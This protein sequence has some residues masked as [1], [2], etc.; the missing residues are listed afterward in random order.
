MMKSFTQ[1]LVLF[2]LVCFAKLVTC[3]TFTDVAQTLSIDANLSTLDNYGAS[4]SFYDFNQDGLD[5]LTF[6]VENDSILFYENT[7]ADFERFYLPIY[8]NG[9]VKQVAWVDID[10]DHDLD[11]FISVYNGTPRLLINDGNFNFTDNSVQ[12]GLPTVSTE[13][14]GVSF[15]DFNNDSYLDF[16]LANYN[17]GYSE[18]D[19]TRLN[20]LYKNNGDGT[21]DNITLSAGVGDSI[22]TSF[23]G[24]W[25]DYDRDGWI[26]L[27]VINDR[28]P[29]EN[30]L[31]KNNGN[32]TFTDVTAGS[33]LGFPG[34]NPMTITI[35]DFNNDGFPDIYTTNIGNGDVTQ[36]FVNNGDGTFSEHSQALGTQ[37]NE[38]TWGAVWIDYDND[39]WEDLYVATGHPSSFFPQVESKF[40]KNHNGQYFTFQNN[41]FQ[42]NMTGA[43]YSVAKGDLN[44]DGFYDIISYND[45]L[46]DPYLWLNSGGT[47][48]Y[49]KLTLEGTT[50]N[51]NAIGAQIRV[52]ANGNQYIKSVYSV[53]NY[54][55]QN[56]Q[57][58]IFGL[59]QAQV[60]D[61]IRVLYPSGKLDKYYNV[62]VNE[63]HYL[64][65][66]ETSNIQV[67]YIG[68]SIFCDNSN[69][70]LFINTPDS[71]TWNNNDDSTHISINT[72]GSYYAMI[73]QPGF[74]FFTDTVQLQFS[75]M[76][77]I[78]ENIESASCADLADGSIELFIN[79]N[80]NSSDY[81]LNWSNGE[82]GLSIINLGAGNYTYYYQDI[83]GCSD[84]TTLNVPSPSPIIINLSVQQELLGG[85]GNIQLIANGGTPPYDYYFNGTQLA[86]PYENLNQGQYLIEILD[87]NNCSEDTLVNVNSILSLSEEAEDHFRIGPNPLIGSSF[88]IEPMVPSENLT[89][90]IYDAT[91]KE[92]FAECYTDL[93]NDKL[94]LDL[95]NLKKGIYHLAILNSEGTHHF[96]LHKL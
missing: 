46:E 5:D 67:Q 74:S 91:G 33:G 76:P 30:T 35:D 82:T 65:E 50:S 42:G 49:I 13:N 10:N 25:F 39:T 55:A 14:Y 69:A 44:N 53:E 54:I 64:V 16:Y 81:S 31:F 7:G 20:R 85:D 36:H 12:A 73:H 27:F 75:T 8:G 92:I 96:K 11:L 56:S 9:Q 37:I 72:S 87:Q 23:Q 62:N 79:A 45:D 68:D 89:I 24:L 48:N 15:A 19:H 4:V 77:Q 95:A 2:L 70:T 41:F 18:S 51:Y 80:I 86:P 40:F 29:F 71:L 17:Y 90:K 57:H 94:T 1:L 58:I 34:G 59:G 52:F 32:E 26:D 78:F 3:Q 88:F 22:K 38:Y 21:F 28:Y 66:G 63:H 47:N 84:T 60:V 83:F 6:A 93:S 61:S 43:S